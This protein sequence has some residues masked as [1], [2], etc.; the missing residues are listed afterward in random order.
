MPGA[1][2]EIERLQNGTASVLFV[3]NVEEVIPSEEKTYEYDQYRIEIPY[4]DTLN[5]DIEVNFDKW[6]K[7]SKDKECDVI[8]DEIR[9]ERNHL[10]ALC[11]WTQNADSPLDSDQKSAWAAYRQALR[12]VPEQQ[13]F[14]YDVIWPTQP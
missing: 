1:A 11:D 14:P 7:F 10:L 4:R 9:T 12:D 3:E 5:A 13:G 2:Y 6:L 8:G